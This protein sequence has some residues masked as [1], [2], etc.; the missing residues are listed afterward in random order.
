MNI[1]SAP[2]TFTNNSLFVGDL[3]KFC[4][5]SDLENLFSTHGE[6]VDAKIK[7]NSTTGKT[8]S[9]GFVTFASDVSAASA[10]HA[11]NGFNLQGRN[12]R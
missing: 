8:L 2:S 7:R 10:M 4:T 3:P 1:I 9:Y 11:L 6:V 12:I 5:E